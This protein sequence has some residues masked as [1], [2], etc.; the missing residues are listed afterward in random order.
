[1]GYADAEAI[2][3]HF[4]M[5]YPKETLDREHAIHELR[6]AQ[7][8]G[9]YEE[10]GVRVRK[11]GTRYHAQVIVWRLDNNE[12]STVGYAKIT[13]DVT[14][15]KEAERALKDSEAKFRIITD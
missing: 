8:H 14:A 11:N 9:R 1:T 4:S 12:G 10:E 2:G 6:M 13:R 15:L 3:R 5:M 7:I